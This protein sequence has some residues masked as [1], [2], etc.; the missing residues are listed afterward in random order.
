MPTPGEDGAADP[1]PFRI[2]RTDPI[3]MARLDGAVHGRHPTPGI[4]AIKNVIM[5][6]CRRL[7]ELKRRGDADGRVM[8]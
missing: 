5:N 4:R 2:A 7:E 6:E 3:L 1:V 8:R